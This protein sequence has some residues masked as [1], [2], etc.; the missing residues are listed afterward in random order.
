MIKSL[1]DPEYELNSWWERVYGSSLMRRGGPVQVSL[2][3][4][5]LVYAIP[6]SIAK[7]EA[8]AGGSIDSFWTAAWWAIGTVTTIGY[9][10]VVPVTTAG[11]VAAVVLM[12]L[13]IGMFGILLIRLS[14]WY[15]HQGGD[16]YT[17]HLEDIQKELRILRHEVHQE[18]LAQ[19][20]R[21]VKHG[22]EEVL[23]E[24]YDDGTIRRSESSYPDKP[25]DDEGDDD[26]RPHP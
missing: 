3:A 20:R 16:P 1:R 2:A 21:W 4:V 15:F 12:M 18:R 5:L 14:R 19:H 24:R 13:G 10:D 7:I 8:D 9:G 26:R 22:A 11:R 23:E 17:E 6:S 25:H